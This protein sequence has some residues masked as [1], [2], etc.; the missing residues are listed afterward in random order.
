MPNIRKPEE[1]RRTEIICIKCSPKEKEKIMGEAEKQQKSIST[2]ALDCTLAGKERRS[3]RDRKRAKQ[4]VLNQEMVNQL[5]R[6]I[7]EEDWDKVKNITNELIKG[8]GKLW[9]N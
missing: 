9:E 3:S 6:N 1:Q 5:V 8:E 2:Y 7:R 4:M